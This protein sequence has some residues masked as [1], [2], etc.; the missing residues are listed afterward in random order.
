MGAFA[1]W[2]SDRCLKWHQCSH[3]RQ[4]G[5]YASR[6]ASDGSALDSLYSDDDLQHE[7]KNVIMICLYFLYTG[8][9]DT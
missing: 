4:R 1:C 2:L 3:F 8:T 7:K 9:L 6:S 5:K